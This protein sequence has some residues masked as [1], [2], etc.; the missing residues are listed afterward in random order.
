MGNQPMKAPCGAR[1]RSGGHCLKPSGWGTDHVG[2][3]RCRLHGGATPI[4]SGRYS[5]VQRERVREL[6]EQFEADPD[7][8][9]I[10]PELAAARALFQD[11]VE[12]YD[13]WRDALLAWHES[14]QADGGAAKP[15]QILDIA[16]AHRLLSEVTKIA[17]RIEDIRAQSAISRADFYRVMTEMG[18]VVDLVVDDEELREKIKRG[19]ME[20]RLA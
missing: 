10:L 16:D 7:P 9:N 12:R 6:I 18:R 4:T 2:Q 1:T 13:E 17:K 20:I 8:L 3:G 11:F 15:R 5:K 14:Y 19:W